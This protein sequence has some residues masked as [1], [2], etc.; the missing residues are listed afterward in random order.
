[1]QLDLLRTHPEQRGLSSL[2]FFRR[3]RQ[4]RQPVRLRDFRGRI[5]AILERISRIITQY[6]PPPPTLLDRHAVGDQRLD[7]PV[8]Y[9]RLSGTRL[10][11][12]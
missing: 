7:C 8:I 10:D 3:L 4:V 11:G 1:M 12:E 6:R 9:A 2:H 5:A